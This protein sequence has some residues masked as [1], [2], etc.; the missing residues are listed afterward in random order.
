[1]AIEYWKKS[2]ILEHQDK[3]G[4]KE[5]VFKEGSTHFSLVS[6]DKEKVLIWKQADFKNWFDALSDKD[7]IKCMRHQPKTGGYSIGMFFK[8]GSFPFPVREFSIPEFVAETYYHQL[9]IMQ[10]KQGLEMRA[11]VLDTLTAK[12][13]ILLWKEKKGI[14]AFLFYLI[15]K[16]PEVDTTTI[17]DLCRKQEQLE[18]GDISLKNKDGQTSYIEVKLDS[19]AI[20]Q[21]RPTWFVEWSS[22]NPN[23]IRKGG[24]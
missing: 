4:Y 6:F 1:M 21:Y 10:H 2:E 13:E 18:L 8:E 3:L 9:G 22:T 17:R 14:E 19:N 23:K 7:E 16:M 12:K 20:R 11:E 5:S 24:G 15:A